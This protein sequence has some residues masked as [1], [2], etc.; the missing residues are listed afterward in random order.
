M[1]KLERSG[2]IIDASIPQECEEILS[3]EAL[4][5]VAELH[6]RF[7]PRRRR[8]LQARVERQKAIDG[9]KLPDFLPETADIRKSDYKVAP[10]PADLMDR[11]V[12]IT[13]PVD[14]KMVINALNSGANMFMADFEDSN[15]PT[16]SNNILG[17]VNMR[18]AVRGTIDYA[19]PEGKQYKLNP[20]H[21]VLLVRP[22]G[23][24]L[25]EKHVT[26][27]G[28]SRIRL[29]LRLRAVLLP[30]R[31]A[32]MA[33]GSAPYFYLPKMQSHLE[34]RLWNDVFVYAQQHCGV[35]N[36]TIRATVLI[37]TILGA[38]EMDE[39]LWELRD[40]SAGL[41]CGR[42]D[43]IFSFIKVLARIRS[44]CCRIVARS[45]WTSTSSRATST[46]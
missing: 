36:G 37:E 23:W 28:E 39:I 17:Q 15:A 6:R 35:P 22:R 46:C 30:Q 25:M 9:G 33:K 41:N 8:L 21:A 38:F 11:R 12:E 10:I 27:G 31:E 2:V 32:A 20:K 43:Y 1:S 14:R 13:G 24:H 18:D 3:P 34:A 44:L 42:W 7:D 26:I 45:R 4:A 5:L 16:W 19:S 40:H 29:F